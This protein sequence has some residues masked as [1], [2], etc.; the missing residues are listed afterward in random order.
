MI[1]L[2]EVVRNMEIIAKLV[3]LTVAVVLIVFTKL[4][5]HIGLNTFL[6]GVYTMFSLLFW[7]KHYRKR[8]SCSMVDLK[9]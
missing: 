1:D 2:G 6:V 8:R 5:D 3:T 4:S 7:I 9:K